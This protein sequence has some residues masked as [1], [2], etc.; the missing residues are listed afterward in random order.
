MLEFIE[1]TNDDMYDVLDIRNACREFFTH[2]TDYITTQEQEQWWLLKELNGYKVWLVVYRDSDPAD[3]D[4]YLAGFCMLRQLYDS[5]RIYATLALYPQFRGHGH[6][7]EIY[8]FLI[9]HHDETWIDVRNDNISSIH[10][11]ENAGFQ[12]HYIGADISEMV[13]RK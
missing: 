2:H 11:A 5:G 1:A 10:A 9:S 3:C 8:K 12:M 7:T 6:G 4:G 13:Y